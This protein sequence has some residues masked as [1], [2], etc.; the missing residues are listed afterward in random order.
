MQDFNTYAD[1]DIKGK[2]PIISN[3]LDLFL[4]ELSL[5]L[6]TEKFSTLGE[7]LYGNPTEDMLWSLNMPAESIKSEIRASIEKYCTHIQFYS[8]D[9]NVEFAEGAIRDIGVIS[10]YIYDNGV[11]VESLSYMY[12]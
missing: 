6:D 5:L 12:D 1:N 9:I 3:K 4:H 2:I 10:I 8:V 11:E 7:R